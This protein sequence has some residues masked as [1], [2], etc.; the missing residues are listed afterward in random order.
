MPMSSEQS[1][2]IPTARVFTPLLEPS[3]YKGAHGGRGS[4]KSHFFAELL[5][6]RHLDRGIRSV[7][8][9]ENQKSLK[10]SAKRLIEDKI[11]SLGLTERHGFKV[12]KESIETPGDGRIIFQGRQDHTAESIKSL[13][14]FH[15][16]WVEEAQTLSAT[17]R[18]I[19]RP[20][21]RGGSSELWFSW[22][23]SR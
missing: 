17:S 2:T 1:L 19:L 5:V 3:R 4:G 22:A 7:C 8:I 15:T 13:E 12:W 9:R 18:Q 21:I 23:R 20:T 16:A 14:G 6:D 11:Q 10:E